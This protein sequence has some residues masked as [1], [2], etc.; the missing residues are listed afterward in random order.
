MD[1]TPDSTIFSKMKTDYDTFRLSE[2]PIQLTRKYYLDKAEKEGKT[3]MPWWLS[4]E[5]SVPPTLTLWVKDTFTKEQ[6][7]LYRALLL[8]LFPFDICNSDYKRPAL[9]LC[10]RMGVLKS[11]F[12]DL[13]TAGGRV[14]VNGIECPKIIDWILKLAPLVKQLLESKEW[15]FDLN[16]YNKNLLDAANP[17]EAWMKQVAEQYSEIKQLRDW[18][19]LSVGIK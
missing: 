15:S 12:R 9:W 19:K 7:E 14:L 17:F 1:I 16:D 2:N 3:Q 18:L 5:V 13:Y 6:E 4:Q 11:N 10:T 8:M